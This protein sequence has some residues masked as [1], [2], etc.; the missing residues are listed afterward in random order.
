MEQ[1][2][3][4]IYEKQKQDDEKVKVGFGRFEPKT[5]KFI[6]AIFVTML[7]CCL[8]IL[9][10]TF[11]NTNLWIEIISLIVMAILLI[12]LIIIDKRNE[13]N[14]QQYYESHK[15]KIEILYKLLEEELKEVSTEKID[16]LI[17]KYE[18][19]IEKY[20]NREKR[21]NSVIKYVVSAFGGILSVSFVNMNNM[22][23]DFTGW[24]SVVLILLISLGMIVTVFYCLALLDTYKFKR[25][26]IIS[27]LK[28]I[29]M[30]LL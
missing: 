3:L 1:Y 19:C 15:R 29:K 17:S 4:D 2:I 16:E 22:G 21:T 12:L 5:R 27:D 26:M 10:E 30:L 6:I 11:K 14:I 24:L 18:I 25:E 13:K 28:D 20:N 8:I 7:V 9:I 23:V